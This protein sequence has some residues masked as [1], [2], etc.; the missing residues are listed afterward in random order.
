MRKLNIVKETFTSSLSNF[1]FCIVLPAMI[2]YSMNSPFSFNALLESGILIIVAVLVLIFSGI[3]AF[4]V[5]RFFDA[6]RRERSV[7]YYTVLFS[8]FT[9]M[10]FPVVSAI[11]GKEGLFYAALFIIP[12]RIAYNTFGVMLFKRGDKKSVGISFN[13]IINPPL[14]AVLIGLFIFIFSVKLIAPIEMTLEMLTDMLT[15]LGMIFAGIILG[16][17]KISNLIGSI[18][19]YTVTILR[20][21]VI[22]LFVYLIL[23]FIGFESYML[24]IPVILSAMPSAATVTIIAEKYGGKSYLGAQC[25]FVTTAFSIITIPLIS[26]LLL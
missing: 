18:A 1:I 20:L 6:E 3:L 2:I 25:T 26:L 10:G 9:F 8:N 13:N 15:P 23:K 22:P 14:I 24:G 4:I 17:G 21:V 7:Y 11:Y 19:I 16:E 12:L 5:F